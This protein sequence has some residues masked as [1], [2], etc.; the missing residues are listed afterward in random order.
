MTTHGLQLGTFFII[1][2]YYWLKALYF[3]IS[4][5]PPTWVRNTSI[6]DNLIEQDTKRPDVW[7]VRE[8]S[9][10]D[11]LRS[12]PFVGDLFI[13]YDVKRLLDKKNL[14]FKNYILIFISTDTQN[15]PSSLPPCLP[16]SL[17]PVRSQP[18]CRCSVLR[19]G[20]FELPNPCGC[21][22]VP[23]GTT[24]HQPPGHPFQWGM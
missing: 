16:W 20:H 10:A 8:P 6:G 3:Y 2:V 1:D 11:G 23:P 19:P 18:P 5:I 24:S 12:T 17:W 13:F 4:I 7:L 22:C 21:C 15:H 14:R 9:M